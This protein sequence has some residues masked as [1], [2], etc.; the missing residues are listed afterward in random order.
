MSHKHQLTRIEKFLAD[1]ESNINDG[2]VILLDSEMEASRGSDLSFNSNEVCT[3]SVKTACSP[4]T[5]QCFNSIQA[6][7]AG[8]II[9]QRVCDT[10]HPVVST[11]GCAN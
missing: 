8:G 3:N 6:C 5:Q 4:N 2:S 7:S 1:L 11:A 9:N 10:P